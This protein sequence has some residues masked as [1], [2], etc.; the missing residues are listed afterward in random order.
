MPGKYL[1]YLYNAVAYAYA[2][3][4]KGKLAKGKINL[5]TLKPNI[6]LNNSLGGGIRKQNSL[7]KAGKNFLSFLNK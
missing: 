7:K 1:K 4:R 2:Y 6:I 3:K 5:K